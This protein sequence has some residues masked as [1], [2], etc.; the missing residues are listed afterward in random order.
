MEATAAGRVCRARDLTL[1]DETFFAHTHVVPRHGGEQRLRVGMHRR[2]V[3]GGLVALLDDAPEIHDGDAIRGVFH[4]RK[5]VGDEQIGKAELVLQV[6]QQVND[7]G[8]DR[9]VERGDRLIENEQARLQRQCPRDADAL[10]LPTRELARQTS[11][12]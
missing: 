7:L 3:D 12:D 8:L 11:R 4:H 2:V 5:V 1:Q 10:L 9:Y 6:L